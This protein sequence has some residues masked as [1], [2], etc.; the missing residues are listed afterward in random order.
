VFHAGGESS[1]PDKPV[2]AHLSPLGRC[3]QDKPYFADGYPFML[4]TRPSIEN[5]NGKLSGRDEN[6]K[7]W[8]KLQIVDEK[9]TDTCG[10][11][12]LNCFQ[13]FVKSPALQ[14]K[15]LLVQNMK[16]LNFFL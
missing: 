16:F 13:A 5:L 12:V 15:I 4:M 6:E 11:W 14:R 8:T 7:S 3:A 10:S 9:L 1:R 2:N